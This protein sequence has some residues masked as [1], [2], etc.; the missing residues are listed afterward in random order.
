ML[1]TATGFLIHQALFA[2]TTSQQSSGRPCS[3]LAFSLDQ[4]EDDPERHIAI[5]NDQGRKIG[6]VPV[7]SRPS[8][9]N[10]AK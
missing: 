6:E 4:P 8:Y 5:I 7:Y 3:P 10:P 9:Q 1:K 2:T